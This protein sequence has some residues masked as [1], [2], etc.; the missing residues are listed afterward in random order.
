MPEPTQPTQ[1]TIDAKADEC[2]LGTVIFWSWRGGWARVDRG[3]SDVYLGPAEIARA[4][5]ER[6]QPGARIC[7]EVRQD[8]HGRKPWARRVR[9]AEPT[10]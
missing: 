3:G 10:A 7:F 4:G 5:I 2:E 1:T 9:L 8:K 6:L